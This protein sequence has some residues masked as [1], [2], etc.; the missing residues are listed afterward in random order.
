MENGRSTSARTRMVRS[1]GS[2]KKQDGRLQGA[3]T[4][5][6]PQSSLKMLKTI[7]PDHVKAVNA[8]D[9]WEEIEFALDS[10]AT[11]TVREKTC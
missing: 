3:P 1:R 5:R 4:A 6:V 7:E 10:G 8:D 9:G 2:E 11:G